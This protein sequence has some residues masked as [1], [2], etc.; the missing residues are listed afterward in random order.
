MDALMDMIV[1]FMIHQFIVPTIAQLAP[2]FAKTSAGHWMMKPLST[3]RAM[4]VWF[5]GLGIFL[6]LYGLI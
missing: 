1:T 5:M 3:N 4:F 2:P 6:R